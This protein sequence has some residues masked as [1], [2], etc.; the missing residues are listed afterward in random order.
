MFRGWSGHLVVTVLQSS[1]T[2]VIKLYSVNLYSG[3]FTSETQNSPIEVGL[4]CGKNRSE[5]A[6][7][8]DKD[9]PVSDWQDLTAV[10]PAVVRGSRSWQWCYSLASISPHGRPIVPIFRSLM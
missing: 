7:G 3:G 6:H 1:V 2:A 8:K 5:K 10:S 4:I 9:T